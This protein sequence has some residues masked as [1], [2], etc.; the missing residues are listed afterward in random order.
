MGF[1]KH[2]YTEL[3]ELT[4]QIMLEV[5]LDPDL[6]ENRETRQY[7]EDAL[8]RFIDRKFLNPEVESDS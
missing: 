4:D 8:C 7:I 6:E 5:G 2:L 1:M 3:G